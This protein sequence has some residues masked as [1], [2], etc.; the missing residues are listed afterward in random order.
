MSEPAAK[1]ASPRH[2]AE[3]SW[4]VSQ[5]RITRL[6]RPYRC[7]VALLM[8][9]VVLQA[10]AGVS[11]PF[12]VRAMLDDAL[13]HRDLNLLTAL[14]LGMIA[15]A[16]GG[17]ALSVASSRLSNGI[18][19]RVMHD[20]RVA[21]YRHLQRMSLAF[22]TRTRT[23]DLQS[24]IAND[25]SS[26]NNAPVNVVASAVQSVTTAAAIAVALL[27]L[28]W[29]LALATLVIMPVYLVFTRG[30]GSRRRGLIRRR[31]TRLSDLTSLVEETMSVAG[32]LL[33]KT[34]GRQHEFAWR[35][36]E[37]SEEIA[38]VE[39]RAAMIGRWRTA[40]RRATLTVIPAVV[41][42]TAGTMIVRGHSAVSI[43]TAV[44]ATTLL[45][46]LISPA[47]NLQGIGM[48]VSASLVAFGRI[49]EMLD[50]PVDIADRPGAVELTVSA[51]H[52]SVREVF[53]RYEQGGP[54]TL[55]NINLDVPPGTTTA[56]AGRTGS[57]KTTLAYLIARLYEPEI[58]RV[59]IDGVDVRDVTLASLAAAV[60][61]VPQEAYLFH[62]TIA[63][64][65]R[66]ARADAT[67]AEIEQA[68]RRARIHDLISSLPDGYDTVV[69]ERGYRFSGGERQRLAIT[70]LLLRN[71]PIVI[72]DEATSA[73]D[74]QTERAVQEALDELADG[75]TTIA[76]AHRLSTVLT[77][78]QIV[79]LEDGRIAE[80]GRS[81][82]LLA[83]NGRF[84]RLAA[85]MAV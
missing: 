65:L 33:A 4:R 29:K 22:F 43:G 1:K 60:G 18:D 82:Q 19:Q 84:A 73:L 34:M 13:P 49:F 50:L 69:G 83:L 76:I 3:A 37:Y 11:S 14:A 81:E 85:G 47:A 64:N 17:G 30:A 7:Q 57:G 21:M 71:P 78:D 62:A 32:V 42:W 27:L 51:G 75:R 10:M 70:R 38:D 72:L 28:S 66:F 9:V 45:S 15:A 74:T 46:R 77:A 59:T 55:T 40:A 36:A 41:Y 16:V 5:R 8:V 12:F 80:R 56:L 61:F 35:F 20:V 26:V 6:F 52:V 63:E 53:F 24:R 31:Q 67:D 79:V 58:G 54:W 23:G 48:N 68:A 39:V 44:A 25:V 2:A